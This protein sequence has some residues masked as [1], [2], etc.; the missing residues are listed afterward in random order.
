MELDISEFKCLEELTISENTMSEHRP[1]DGPID[2]WVPCFALVDWQDSFD[3]GSESLKRF[4]IH[5]Y[6]FPAEI[7]QDG[8]S[9][10][11]D[12]TVWL[13]E[14]AVVDIP[15]LYELNYRFQIR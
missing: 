10:L 9:I 14:N 13:F 1:E 6:R 11:Q 3:N 12:Y 7:T 15:Y 8:R 2:E 4:T 5:G